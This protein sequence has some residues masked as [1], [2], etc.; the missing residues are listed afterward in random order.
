M[1]IEHL[2]TEERKLETDLERESETVK[3]LIS[4]SDFVVD[5]DEAD[6]EIRCFWEI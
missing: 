4:S 5:E 3:R 1:R 2:G 6:Q